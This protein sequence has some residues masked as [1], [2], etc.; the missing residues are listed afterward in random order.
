MAQVISRSGC[1][2]GGS[3]QALLLAKSLVGMVDVSA[4]ASRGGECEKKAL[5]LG[6]PHVTLSMGWDTRSLLEFVRFAKGFDVL[7]A[8]KGKAL[9][10]S[11]FSS[12]ILG[13]VKVFAN[14]GVSFP[15]ERWNIWKYRI[16]LTRAVVCVS[17]GVMRLLAQ[18]GLSPE[19]LKV[20]YGSIDQRFFKSEAQKKVCK[21]LG[22]DATRFRILLVGNFRPWKGHTILA[23]A[24]SSLSQILSNGELIF[25]GKES[26]KV[27]SDARS[28]LGENFTSLGY[29][30]DVERII[31]SSDVLVNASTE[32]E[33]I[34]G[35]IREAMACGRCV[36]AS[37]LDGNLEM[38]EHGKTGLIFPTGNHLILAKRLIFLASYPKV[39][40]KLAC[41]ARR[42]ASRFTLKARAQ[43]ILSIYASR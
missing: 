23:E 25:A 11:L 38:V 30:R 29:R 13:R 24:F 20:V 42:F 16:P 37:D 1:S 34:P 6:L 36:V 32:G 8:H 18:Q 3:I 31:A 14:R 21:E 2:S 26:V 7:H 9:S 33:G 5:E 17:F 27:L 10:F 39:A 40:K 19:K 43:R 22:L 28:I 4:F 15:L 41:N 12:W 35:V